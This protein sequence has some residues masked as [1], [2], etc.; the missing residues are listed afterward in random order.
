M[1]IDESLFWLK[2]NLE[3]FMLKLCWLST[4][5]KYLEEK[6]PGSRFITRAVEWVC[7][8]TI[9]VAVNT[10]INVNAVSLLCFNRLFEK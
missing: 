2:F 10:A 4:F 3:V 8:K 6:Q 7:K 9:Y 1:N 5:V